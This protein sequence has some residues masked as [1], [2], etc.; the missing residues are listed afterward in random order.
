MID[1]PQVRHLDVRETH[2]TESPGNRV[3]VL[4][5]RVSALTTAS[6]LSAGGR[7]PGLHYHL[8]DKLCFVLHGTMTVQV[9]DDTLRLGE[10]SLAL[11]PSGTG[12]THWNDGPGNETHLEMIVPAPAGT[13]P[14]VSL[15]IDSIAHVPSEH[16]AVRAASFCH[17]DRERSA[18]IAPGVRVQMLTE[19]S[20]SQLVVRYLEI[21][22]GSA[23][24]LETVD[25]SDQYYFVLEGQLSIDV[26]DQRL[27][28]Q[29]GSLAVLPGGTTHRH[30]NEVRSTMRC[31]AVG[32]S[33][34]AV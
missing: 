34:R 27:V 20:D 1:R 16:R 29:A 9:G 4:S 23:C 31:L 18:E 26:D 21:D 8:G 22:E 14:E 11:I 10:N 6:H 12:H 2:E 15:L 30:F 5:K 13:G 17:V 3:Q 19:R 28:V 7:G 32:T 25:G 33:G 24:P